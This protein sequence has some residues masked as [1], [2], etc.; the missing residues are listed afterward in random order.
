MRPC[1]L[2]L[3]KGSYRNAVESKQRAHYIPCC[4]RWGIPNFTNI[5]HLLLL[6][7]QVGNELRITDVKRVR[8][9]QCR[10][11][12][13]SGQSSRQGTGWRGTSMPLCSS[14]SNRHVVLT[15][16]RRRSCADRFPSAQPIAPQQ[17]QRVSRP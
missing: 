10:L 8:E 12:F 15:S 17:D 9:G 2:N 13:T 11:W 3:K 7:F 16:P 1:C 6:S 4:L 5:L 14:R